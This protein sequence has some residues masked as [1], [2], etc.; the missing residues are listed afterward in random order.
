M[1]ENYV[2][3]ILFPKREQK[4][5]DLLNI[6]RFFDNVKKQWYTLFIIMPA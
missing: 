6:D 3:R 4:I 2:Q 1:T 5:N